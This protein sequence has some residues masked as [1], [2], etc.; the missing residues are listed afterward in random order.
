MQCFGPG[1]L[2]FVVGIQ[3]DFCVLRTQY[4]NYMSN[5]SG[6]NQNFKSS[7]KNNSKNSSNNSNKNS[8]QN[9]LMTGVIKRHPDGFGFF[10][11]DD[12]ALVDVYV[13]AHSMK[14]AMTNDRVSLI[15]EKERDG[16]FRGD[17][18]RILE[19]SQKQ[20][21]G[22][23]QRLNPTWGIVKD[24]GKGWGKDLK[25]SMDKTMGAK[26]GELVAAKILH[27][28]DEDGIFEGEVI[29]IIG[30]ALSA[31]N[32]IRRVIVSQNIPD[33]FSPGTLAEAEKLSVNP[34]E[35]DFTGRK[36]LQALAFTT[37]DGATAKDFDDAV[38]TE[39]TK[40]GF[41]LY[42]AIADV[43]HYVKAGSEMDKDAYERG[44]SVYFPNF[45]VPMLPE[46]LSN[47]LC[48][49]NPN[50]PR[51]ALV[52]EM[53]FD[54]TGVMT[55]SQFYEAVIQ[56]HCRSTY[57]E[58]QEL[59]DQTASAE[60]KNKLFPVSENILRC[61]DLAKILMAKRFRDGALDL[62]VPETE[63]EIDATGEPI[64][65]IKSERIFAHRLIEELMLAANVAV[66]KFLSSR[67]IPSF[68]RIHELPD[69]EKIGLLQR[70]IK[71]MGHKVS[72][73]GGKL[74]KK[75]TR[76][77][78]QFEGTPEA[79]IVN[80]MTLRSMSQAK[81]SKD[82]IGHFGLGFDFYTHFT[83]PIRRYSDLIVHRLLKN[84]VLRNSQYRLMGEEDLATA[85]TWLSATE[86]KSAKA[87]RQIQAIKKARFMKKMV[88]ESFEGMISSVTKFG[89]F[90]LLRQFNI[91]GLIRLDDLGND[92]WLYDEES[93]KLVAKRSGFSYS[94]GD[95]LKVVVAAVDIEQGQINFILDRD[96]DKLQDKLSSQ[97]AAQSTVF[98]VAKQDEVKIKPRYSSLSE[99]LD[100]RKNDKKSDS[101]KRITSFKN[102][103]K[104]EA[105]EKNRDRSKDR[106]RDNDRAQ[107]SGKKSENK[108]SAG[109]SENRKDFKK[110][111]SVKDHSDSVRQARPK[112]F[113]R[114]NKSR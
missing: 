24:E 59:I 106:D 13:P 19:R 93:L 36:D 84:Q 38:L 5:Q 31:M 62:E 75:L 66:A 99:Y 107:K 109:T 70:Y 39:M 76:T 9:K 113:S 28:P 16:R 68:Y 98:K 22:K 81:Y 95:Q 3:H 21:A 67:E 54:F 111:G 47:G 82:N 35:R 2:L 85:G 52:A 10:I 61:A 30:D 8:N 79:Q 11:P 102:K 41:H 49:L 34:D 101:G 74:Q 64:D 77:L 46:K 6:G 55:G 14:T 50:V 48:S 26:D 40:D 73:A 45:V 71:S 89:V 110:R 43:S 60:V 114:K 32:D 90:V 87:E 37:I 94:M 63:L 51:L 25:I 86:Q 4:D 104:D 23:F 17:I 80:I 12:S 112:K 27:Y 18:V 88:G 58:V 108:S 15:A 29:E 100:S 57:G 92:Q 91:D 83:S 1:F 96:K 69:E 53:S 103:E 42:V 56:S 105:R 72:F 65:I 7:S 44:N 20:I 33:K 97:K 78:Q